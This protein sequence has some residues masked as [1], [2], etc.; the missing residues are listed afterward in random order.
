MSDDTELNRLAEL[1]PR[2]AM[3]VVQQSMRSP[4]GIAIDRPH[5]RHA[6]LVAEMVAEI[7]DTTGY[8]TPEAA[9]A[10]LDLRTAMIEA[11]H[12]IHGSDR[13]I[14]PEPAGYDPAGLE[15]LRGTKPPDAVLR[16]KWELARVT[17]LALEDAGLSVADVA[18]DVGET[19]ETLERW[20]DGILHDVSLD[21]LAQIYA[22]VA[23]RTGKWPLDWLIGGKP[24][25]TEDREEELVELAEI[26][27]RIKHER[28]LRRAESNERRHGTRVVA[29][30]D[31]VGGQ[32]RIDGTRMPIAQLLIYMRGGMT[33]SEISWEWAHLPPGWF[34]AIIAW[35]DAQRA[36]G[37][38]E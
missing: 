33:E 35:I 38:G 4:D 34:D 21:R 28:A 25:A 24:G 12:V 1:L 13:G 19:A 15:L 26:T 10:V 5:L 11:L 9:S 8:W 3:A 37:D 22:V 18:G 29:T 20:L 7:N 32:P 30:A 14:P 23:A 36:M 27:A 16:A 31:T 2:L 17:A 6:W